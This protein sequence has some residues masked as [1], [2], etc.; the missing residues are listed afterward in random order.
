MAPQR[1]QRNQKTK[2]SDHFLFTFIFQNKLCMLCISTSFGVL[3][4]PEEHPEEGRT[5]IFQQFS[6]F[7]FLFKDPYGGAFRASFWA[8]W[9]KNGRTRVNFKVRSCYSKIAHLYCMHLS[10]SKGQRSFAVRLSSKYFHAIHA[11]QNTFTDNDVGN[12]L[13]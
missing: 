13:G 7:L 5:A 8:V 2:K 1:N 9:T 4:N 6:N 11:I 10:K 12:F 3:A